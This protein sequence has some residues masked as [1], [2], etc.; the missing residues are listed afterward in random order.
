MERMTHTERE[1]FIQGLRDLADFLERKPGLGLSEW[2]EITLGIADNEM[3]QVDATS[4]EHVLR[5]MKDPGVMVKK[6]HAGDTL[7]LVR[8]FGPEGRWGPRIVYRARYEREKVCE[9][10]VIGTREVKKFG[11]Y[12]DAERAAELRAELDALQV[13]EVVPE[14][15]YDCKP[16][17]R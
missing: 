16:V 10:K 6:E 8:G 11:V 1:V 17:L 5:R 7:S 13:V 4:P 9:A 14:V 2:T 15:E 3:D 12:T